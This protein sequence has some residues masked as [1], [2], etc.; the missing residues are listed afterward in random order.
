MHTY[1]HTYTHTYIHTHACKHACTHTYVHTYVR[2]YIHTYIHG[3]P[4]TPIVINEM[5]YPA[6]HEQCAVTMVPDFI[7]A[8]H[9]RCG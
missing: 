5:T 3:Y 1:I 8:T 6:M 9:D 4:C 2:T 7:A